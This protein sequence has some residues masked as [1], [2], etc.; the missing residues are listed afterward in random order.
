MADELGK[1]GSFK[2]NENPL[3]TAI[4]EK[5]KYS[6]FNADNCN[7]IFKNSPVDFVLYSKALTEKSGGIDMTGLKI[8]IYSKKSRA[9]KMEYK[10]SA[11]GLNNENALAENI[12]KYTAGYIKDQL[13]TSKESIKSYT[14]SDFISSIYGNDIERTRMM[15]E[16]GANPDEPYDS[17]MIMRRDGKPDETKIIKEYLVFYIIQNEKLSTDDRIEFIRLF[18]EFKADFNV[19]NYNSYT[20]LNLLMESYIKISNKSEI[21]RELLDAGTDPNITNNEGRTALQSVVNN[22]EKRPID[23]VTNMVKTLVDHGA[24]M[25]IFDKYGT[26][27]LMKAIEDGNF[28]VVGMFLKKG[29]KNKPAE[30]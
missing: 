22:Y 28:T 15:L 9:I 30:R 24:D 7:E 11:G 21:M 3:S 17:R 19:M 4:L 1:S 14:S 26:S 16:A 25:N 12:A 5:L 6:E 27:P 23:E 18:H 10:Y 29:G 2:I 8:K 20:P 13:I